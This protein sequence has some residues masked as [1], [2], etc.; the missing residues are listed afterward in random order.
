MFEILS[1]LKFIIPVSLRNTIHKYGVDT[2]MYLVKQYYGWRQS[3]YNYQLRQIAYQKEQEGVT[4]IKVYQIFLDDEDDD[5][6]T[7]CVRDQHTKISLKTQNYTCIFSTTFSK[8]WYEIHYSFAGQDFI[9]VKKSS[10]L[11]LPVFDTNICSTVAKDE[12]IIPILSCS[13]S[14][15]QFDGDEIKTVMIVDNDQVILNNLKKLFGLVKI[16]NRLRIAVSNQ[17]FL[18]DIELVKWL[19]IKLN[20]LLYSRDLI[21]TVYLLGLESPIQL[22]SF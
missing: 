18:R 7:T 4:I 11:S 9:M 3:W 16:D 2:S 13:L 5:I 15:V 12:H 21:L 17:D 1:N 19:A 14:T 22:T 6:L 20:P 8:C 10:E